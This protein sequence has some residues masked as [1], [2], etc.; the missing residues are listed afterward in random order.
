M[1]LSFHYSGAFKNNVPLS[2]LIEEVKDIAQANQWKYTVY[3]KQFSEADFGKDT[4]KE[5]IFGISFSPQECEP[6]YLCFLS[7]GKLSSPSHLQMFGR[8]KN[9]DDRKYLY[10]LSVKTQYAGIHTHKRI[11]DLLKYLDKKYLSEL[12]VSDE[13]QYWETG[14]D[15]LLEKIFRRYDEA[16]EMLGSALDRN[17][18]IPTESFEQYLQRILRQKGKK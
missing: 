4:Y 3:E 6:V 8:S 13:G 16:F 7:N 14:D 10:M 12:K 9:P 15:E 11:I 18:R 1:G 5:K 2:D 17:S